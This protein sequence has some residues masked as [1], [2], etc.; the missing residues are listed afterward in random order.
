MKVLQFAGQMCESEST[1]LSKLSQTWKEKY[2]I[3][4]QVCEIIRGKYLGRG[5]GPAVEEC[6]REQWRV[7]VT[8][9]VGRC[10]NKDHYCAQQLEWTS[11]YLKEL[12]DKHFL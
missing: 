3:I 11:E 5:G 2:Y 8:I 10:H 9:H 4:F 6:G 1:I 12:V 7:T